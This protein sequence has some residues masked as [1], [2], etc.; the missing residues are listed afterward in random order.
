MDVP[1]W[2]DALG[3]A[4]MG[5]ACLGALTAFFGSIAT[6]QAAL[7][8]TVWVETWRL[9]GLLVFAAMFALLAVRPRLSPALWALTFLH[10]TAMGLSAFML[11]RAPDAISAAAV[12]AR[13]A[14]LIAIAYAGTRGGVPGG[15]SA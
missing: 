14:V 5:L 11:S 6:I 13:P 2:Q 8:E 9:F 3:R 10:K 7:V 15:P 12:D 1:R 4:F